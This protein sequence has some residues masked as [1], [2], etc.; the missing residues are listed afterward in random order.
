MKATRTQNGF[1]VTADI[2]HDWRDRYDFEKPLDDEAAKWEANGAKPYRTSTSW[3]ERMKIKIPV[4][5]SQM[6]QP[7]IERRSERNAK[8]R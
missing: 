6:L 2:V 5:D 8:R 1:E 7:V 3:D 4:R